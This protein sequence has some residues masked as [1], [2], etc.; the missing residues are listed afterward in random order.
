MTQRR[1]KTKQPKPA[2]I[3]MLKKSG[4]IYDRS[5]L[6]KLVMASDGKE[7]SIIRKSCLK[8]LTS[9]FN[10]RLSMMMLRMAVIAVETPMP[11]GKDKTPMDFVKHIT[12]INVNT[13]PI[14]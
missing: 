7:R 12:E 1:R 5:E 14:T 3:M 6:K 11:N 8:I 13:P 4:M 10:F 9:I 2:E